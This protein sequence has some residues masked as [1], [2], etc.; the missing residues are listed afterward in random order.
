M[1]Q[2]AS[3]IL[4]SWWRCITFLFHMMAHCNKQQY[5][6]SYT[7]M[8]WIGLYRHLSLS[9]AL[10]LSSLSPPLPLQRVFTLHFYWVSPPHSHRALSRF[11]SQPHHYNERSEHR[12]WH[13]NETAITNC[14]FDLQIECNTL[15]LAKHE[16]THSI[17]A[18]NRLKRMQQQ[19]QQHR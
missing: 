18:E 9:I 7:K 4:L 19:Q 5:L 10:S 17:L 15:L 12:K 11:I 6:Y 14:Q 16:Q 3:S 13:N 1:M 2:S 8:A